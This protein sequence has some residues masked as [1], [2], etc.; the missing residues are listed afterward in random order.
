MTTEEFKRE[1]DILYNNIMSNQAPSIDA[2]EKS[3][4]LTKAQEEIVASIYEGSFE[5]VENAR[6]Y[7]SV[8]VTTQTFD[9]DDADVVTPEKHIT[10]KS[11]FFT[12]NSEAMFITYEALKLKEKDNCDNEVVVLVKPIK[13]DEYYRV[14]KNPFRRARR[15]EALRLN[16]E[17]KLEIISIYPDY[18]Y[19]VRYIRKPQPI[20]LYTES[21]LTINSKDAENP[22][23]LDST[24]HRTI[25]DRAV[26]LATAAYKQ[27]QTS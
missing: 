3:V 25:L 20:L 5:Q 24:L 1:F 21:G 17:D 16:A 6:E 4:F 19:Q 26:A 23:E 14:S 22:C 18:F 11:K 2:Y 13:Q 12:L 15:T 8:L 10:P 7:L 27:V 9:S